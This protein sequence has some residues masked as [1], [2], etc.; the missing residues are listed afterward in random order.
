MKDYFKKKHVL[1][2]L[3]YD[4]T[5]APIAET[6]DQARLDN[7]T[8]DILE[9][10]AGHSDCRVAIVSGR[11]LP[12]IRSRVGLKHITYVGNH[13]LEIFGPKIYFE[14]ARLDRTRKTFRDIIN[15]LRL[16]SQ[17]LKGIFFEDKGATLSIHYRMVEVKKLKYLE[18][19]FYQVVDP[20]V[21]SKAVKV[22]KG[23]KVYEIR[24]PVE[25][26]KGHAAL[27]LL[28]EFQAE[29]RHKDFVAVYIGDDQTD[30]DAFEVLRDMALT[31]HVGNLRK[32][33]A[34]YYLN[35]AEEVKALLGIILLAK[36]S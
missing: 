32:S 28:K 8:R 35:N 3:D 1:L 13:G 30:E 31:I 11:G 17:D 6:P 9:R 36:E 4:G 10:L 29:L 18:K 5:L 34:K 22:F 23:K 12:D 16:H 7:K 15:N 21:I 14:S 27:W 19:I 25:W 26:N 20:Y 33:K 24:P 2:F